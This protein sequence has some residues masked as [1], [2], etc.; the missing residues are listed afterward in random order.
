MKSVSIP[1]RERKPQRAPIQR[2]EADF[3]ALFADDGAEQEAEADSFVAGLTSALE[4]RPAEVRHLLMT[5][6]ALPTTRRA[7]R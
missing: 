5:A 4:H 6:L 3:P 1:P 7:A 2:L